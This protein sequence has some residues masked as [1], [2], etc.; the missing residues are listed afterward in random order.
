MEGLN[1]K[2]Y[3]ITET[4][5]KYHYLCCDSGNPQVKWFVTERRAREH[6]KTPCRVCVNNHIDKSDENMKKEANENEHFCRV[7][8]HGGLSE[9][10][11]E[12]KKDIDHVSRL[13]NKNNGRISEIEK[14]IEILTEELEDL[15]FIGKLLEKK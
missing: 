5:G 14:E 9:K 13:I 4:G 3:W 1:D 15:R 7:C 2:L 11:M 10:N 12:N 6:K 8:T